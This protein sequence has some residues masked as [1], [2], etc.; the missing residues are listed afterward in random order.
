MVCLGGVKPTKSSP[1]RRDWR[2]IGAGQY[3]LPS[4]GTFGDHA[5]SSPV[6][7]YDIH[8]NHHTASDCTTSLLKQKAHTLMK[9]Q[10][11]GKNVSSVRDILYQHCSLHG[12]APKFSREGNIDIFAYPFQ[13]ADKAMLFLLQWRTINIG[14]HFLFWLCLLQVF[15]C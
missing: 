4:G 15:L 6:S 7:S 14:A 5:A 2:Y 10:A 1:W 3:N 13:I 11:C 12:R 9:G 8:S